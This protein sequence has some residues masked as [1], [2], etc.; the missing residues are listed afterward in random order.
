MVRKEAAPL[1]QLRELTPMYRRCT[2][3]RPHASHNVGRV[4][5]VARRTSA[6]ALGDSSPWYIGTAAAVEGGGGGPLLCE[7]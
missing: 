4:G 5:Y 1:L 3:S 7:A 6:P 2:S